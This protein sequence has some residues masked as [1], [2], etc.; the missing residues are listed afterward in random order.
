[1]TR[2]KPIPP[3]KLI[4]GLQIAQANIVLKVALLTLSLAALK[5]SS[6]LLS[7]VYALI[8]LIPAILSCNRAFI[9][10]VAFL[11]ARYRSLVLVYIIAPINK[12]GTGTMA[13]AA[14]VGLIKN[15][16]RLTATICNKATSPCSIPSM[17]T[18]SMDV[19]SSATLV[20]ISPVGRLSN[21]FRGSL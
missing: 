16:T 6:S 17:R 7:M 19:T 11:T 1:M 3:I 18:L 2:I 10:E 14:K 12:N 4:E 9:S 20:I 21:H 8:C 15:I 5:R 13:Q